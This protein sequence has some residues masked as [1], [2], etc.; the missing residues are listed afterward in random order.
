[1][2]AFIVNDAKVRRWAGSF[3]VAGF[4]VFLVALPLYYLAGPEPRIEDTAATSVFVTRASTF[5]LARATLADPLIMIGFLV[6]LAGFRHSIRQARPDYE[7]VSSLV[8]AS[9][10]VVITLELVGDAL[11]AGAALDTFAKAEPTIVRGLIEAS[12]PFFGAVGLL[13]SALF[14]SS[15]GYVT[16]ASGALPKWT[17]WVAWG[18]AVTNLTAAPSILSG[19]DYRA[20]YTATGYVTMIGQGAL[21]IWFG[22]ASVSMIIVKPVTGAS[23]PATGV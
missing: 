21:V 15:A 14:L 4:V 22:A 17:G 20:F 11:Q 23:T 3:G 12:F 9:G 6:F 7:W 19:P 8:L 2:R 5:I 18:A 1:L 13:M 10:L 16:L